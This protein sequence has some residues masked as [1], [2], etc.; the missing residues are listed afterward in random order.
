MKCSVQ[1]SLN[2]GEIL[3]NFLTLGTGNRGYYKCS[4]KDC[5]AK[6]MVQPTDEDSSIFEVTYVGRHTCSGTV[7]RRDRSR[8]R[9]PPPVE[10][11]V[12]EA[13]RPFG[14]GTSDE[15]NVQTKSTV[16]KDSGTSGGEC[17]KRPGAPVEEEDEE[18]EGGEEEEDSRLTGSNVEPDR[19]TPSKRGR[20]DRGNDI[21]TV[22]NTRT[23]STTTNASEEENGGGG[24]AAAMDRDSNHHHQSEYSLIQDTWQD[25][26]D[27]N[28]SPSGHKSVS[29]SVSP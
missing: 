7:S 10:V 21:S 19:P 3:L 24:E 29:D 15:D 23:T 12:Q 9:A 20:V 18:E 13:E 28:L 22:L 4:V 6:K 2:C 26:M 1:L 11:E 27:N 17:K 16:T 25:Y 8:A 14:R 5:R